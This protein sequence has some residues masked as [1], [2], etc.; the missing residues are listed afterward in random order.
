MLSLVWFR[1]GL[2]T[3]HSKLICLSSGESAFIH[4]SVLSSP[5][6]LRWHIS[7]F[8]NDGLSSNLSASKAA[9]R[10]VKITV[11]AYFAAS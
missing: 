4:F 3:G 10:V 8:A 2:F 5:L 9:E 11:N 6:K 1:K 7:L